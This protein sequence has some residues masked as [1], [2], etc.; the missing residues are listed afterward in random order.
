LAGSEQNGWEHG[1]A[2]LFE[3]RVCVVTPDASTRPD[4]LER[5]E[6]FWRTLGMRLVRM[7]PEE[8]DRA[9]AVT[10]HVPHVV[11]AALAVQL[12]DELRDLAAT[13]FRDT[14]RIAA[15]D[16]ELWTAIL[17]ANADSVSAGIDRVM[18]QLAAF[19]AVI[20]SGDESGLL[21]LLKIARE[22]RDLL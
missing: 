3:G 11:A 6:D 14:T 17:L 16:P 19:R 22:R 21:R 18:E 10:S 12:T 1:D 2:E 4:V 7:S 9:L 20:A 13:G 5:V 8:H 15:G